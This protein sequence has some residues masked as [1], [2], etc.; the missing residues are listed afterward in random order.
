MLSQNE[1][2]RMQ[3]EGAISKDYFKVRDLL[4][5]QYAIVWPAQICYNHH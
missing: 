1:A 5:N 3:L 2:G 4:Y